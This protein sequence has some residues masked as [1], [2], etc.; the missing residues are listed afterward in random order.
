[1]H[2]RLPTP[3]HGWRAFFGEVGVIVLGVLIALGLGQVASDIHDRAIAE[4][5]RDAIRAEVREN[6]WWLETRELREPCITRRLAE[7]DA[8]LAQARRGEPIPAVQ[9][10][11]D[12]WHAK[13]TTLRWETNAQAGRA[14]LFPA[15]EQRML[16]NMY[17]TTRQFSLAQQ[18]EETLWPKMAF[19]QGLHQLTPLDMHD[20]SIFLAQAHHEN[21]IVLLTL[22]RAHQ[23]AQMMNITP[24]N[25]NSERLK[26]SRSEVCPA[27]E[28]R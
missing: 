2:V 24:D 25:P 20:L 6:L 10:I 8:L 9:H 16:D 4:E 28:S 22:R 15:D 5:A 21:R 12:L 26:S 11:D 1:M 3:L 23:W 13:I 27:L 19:I 18:E 17:Y 7:L 14:S